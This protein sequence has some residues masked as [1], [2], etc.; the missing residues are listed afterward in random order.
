MIDFR[1]Y[2][3]YYNSNYP[4]LDKTTPWFEF[5]SYIFACESL[6]VIPSIQRFMRYQQYL[7]SIGVI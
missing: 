7:K 1:K 4:A 5:N 2:M 6:G 3:G